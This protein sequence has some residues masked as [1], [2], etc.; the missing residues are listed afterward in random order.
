MPPKKDKGKK[1]KKRKLEKDEEKYFKKMGITAVKNP[2]YPPAA[3]PELFRTEDPLENKQHMIPHRFGSHRNP[4]P[5]A[6]KNTNVYSRAAI[7]H[8]YYDPVSYR[9]DYYK[10]YLND[11]N[12]KRILNSMIT[13]PSTPPNR[14]SPTTP[15][16]LSALKNINDSPKP[17]PISSPPEDIYPEFSDMGFDPNELPPPPPSPSPSPSPKKRKTSK[18]KG[19]KK[20]CRNCKKYYTCKHKHNCYNKTRRKSKKRNTK[21]RVKY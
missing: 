2:K 16:I 10:N 21:K 17:S 11:D 8:L 15:E 7:N 20:Q 18:S 3:M 12:E 6:L 13:P 9:G 5:P 19:G 4:P 1:D 14:N